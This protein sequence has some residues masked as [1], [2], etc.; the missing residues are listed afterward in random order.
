MAA[1]SRARKLSDLGFEEQ[2]R[3]FPYSTIYF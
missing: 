2:L 3:P 1:V